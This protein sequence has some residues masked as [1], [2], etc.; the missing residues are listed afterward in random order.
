MQLLL[1]E[2]DPSISVPLAEGLIREGFDVIVAATGAAALAAPPC[3]I[4]LLDLGLPDLEGRVV[5]QRLRERSAVPIIVVSAR[6]EEIDRVILLELGADD[7]VVKPFGFRELVARI[8][9]VTRRTKTDDAAVPAR[10]ITVGDLVLDQR[11]RTV[12]LGGDTIALTPKEYDLLLCL[13]ADPG[14]VRSRE[15]L[16]HEVWDEHW[17]GSTKTLDVHVASLRKKLRPEMIETVRSVGYRLT[18]G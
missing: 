18:E 12:T 8:R 13:A 10:A 17:W 14:A 4:V 9:A 2:D 15:Q 3:D 6:G 11:S 1:V 7:Y 16:I 5:C